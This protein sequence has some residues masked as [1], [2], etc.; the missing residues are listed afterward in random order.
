MIKQFIAFIMVFYLM[1]CNQKSGRV[2]VLKGYAVYILPN[3]V[4]FIETKDLPD[5]NYVEHFST[6][7]FR[8]AI[9]F[10]PNCEI[11]RVIMKIKVDTLFDE[12]PELKEYA[13]FMRYPLI[14]PASIKIIDTAS[15]PDQNQSNNKFKMLLKGKEIEFTHTEFNGVVIDLQRLG[16]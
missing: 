9:S 1:G 3:Y 2:Q 13:T 8:H 14:F 11:E 10:K 6:H 4:R 5:T 7:N 15:T 12:N 16:K